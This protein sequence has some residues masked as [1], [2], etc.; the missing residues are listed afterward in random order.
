MVSQANIVILI[1]A[2]ST[3]CTV[4][5]LVALLLGGAR[6]GAGRVLLAS[7]VGSLVW[8]VAG[9][10]M[11]MDPGRAMA[12]NRVMIL[13][14]AWIFFTFFHFALL[15][16]GHR[17]HGW[18]VYT[19]YALF[20]IL[21]VLDI[22]G[23]VIH[24]V[25]ITPTTFTYE[26]GPAMPF[27]F[28][29]GYLYLGLALYYL[30]RTYRTHSDPF[31]RNKIRY[32]ISG[33]VV[34]MIG[35]ASNASPVLGVFALDHVGN[36]I[37]VA[38]VVYAI[39]RHRLLDLRFVLRSGLVYSG[40]TVVVT[41]AYLLMIYALGLAT[42]RRSG[43]EQSLQAIALAV[44]F[45]VAILLMRNVIQ[46]WADRV[47][48]RDR[49]DYQEL[50]H[51]ASHALRETLDLQDL[52]RTTMDL[53][54]RYLHV[55]R[56]AIFLLEGNR[57]ACH[58]RLR[59]GWSQAPGRSWELALDSPLVLHLKNDLGPMDLDL[60]DSNPRFRG[61]LQQ[62][63]ALLSDLDARLMIPLVAKGTVVGILVLG[64]K[65]SGEAWS[66][67]ELS[68]LSTLADQLGVA[69]D[70]ARLYG[71]LQAS[72]QELKSTQ[73]HLVQT[74]R[75]L[76]M[77]QIASGV[78]HDFNNLL[79]ALQGRIDLAI[80]ECRDEHVLSIL[81]A[82]KRSAHRGSDTVK[83][84]LAFTRMSADRDFRSLE[85]DE[86]LEG[87]LALVE[88]QRRERE[89]VA[90]VRIEV[91]RNLD[92]GCRVLGSPG[93]LR[94]AFV[95]LFLNAFD[96]M[97]K[98]GTLTVKSMIDGDLV[99]ITVT[100][101]GVGMTEEVRRQVFDPFFTTKGF[102]G[103]G[104]GLSMV[105]AI[106]KRH[107]GDVTVASQ[108]WHGSTFR[109]RLPHVDDVPDLPAF[110]PV[111]DPPK[112]AEILVVEDDPEVGEILGAMIVNMGLKAFVVHDA[113]EALTLCSER[114]FDVVLTDL[115][116]P[117]MSGRTLAKEIGARWPGTPVVMVTGW[118]LDDMD[119]SEGIVQMLTKPLRMD[120][121]KEAIVRAMAHRAN[122]P[123]RPVE[124][125]R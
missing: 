59:R 10:L 115:G 43:F 58:P 48:F 34:F 75:L 62:E 109:V 28:A 100:D 104:L 73:D 16:V 114:P 103:S 27:V 76:A 21:A 68:L 83:R 56:Q 69:I 110:D 47:F 107:G 37:M 72:Y 80:A 105:Y 51:N 102:Q 112:G 7:V 66:V 81:Q 3:V 108:P 79:T 67:D 124:D 113:L 49:F 89:E 32:P 123:H 82:L 18:L 12:W 90:G 24:S 19:G 45:A 118:T 41:A 52:T 94:D 50:L 98:G 64:S 91:V 85:I 29:A 25:T 15:F 65:R 44:A 53:L 60:V 5:L 54:D 55:Q 57:Y 14:M 35:G 121:L 23:F 106:A 92:A 125:P 88:T 119:P 31:F 13:G 61:L 42:S 84:L 1:I 74:E 77:G 97:P 11:F 4:V 86:I 38:L 17:R 87:T 78:A 96:A 30:L 36:L 20:V 71:H 9:L 26:P 33:L 120:A 95:N 46:H 6:P 40:I 122:A 116:L 117:G 99:V 22:A 8:N 39:V 111:P 63:R 93:D 101:T 2:C 70:H